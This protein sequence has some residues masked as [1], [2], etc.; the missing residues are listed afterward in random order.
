MPKRGWE[1]PERNATSEDVYVNRRK[2]LKTAGLSSLGAAAL[3]T[4]CGHEK[5]FEPFED[6]SSPVGG[7]SGTGGSNT[8]SNEPLYPA[9]VNDAFKELDRP[10]TDE[11]IAGS[12]NNF[13]EFSQGKTGIMKLAESF[14]ANPWTVTVDG[15][16]RN[17]KTYDL[18]DLARRMPLEERL[19]RL[20]CV[21]AW[22]MAIPWTGFPMKALIDE[23]EP[24]SNASYVKMTTF[25]DPQTAPGQWN[26]PQWPWPYVEGLRMEEA[27]NELSL[28]ATGIY[29][30]ALPNQHGAP[31]RLVVPWKYGFK[32]IKSI[33]RIEFTDTAPVTFWNTLVPAEY[34]FV[35]NV[36]PDVPHPRWSQ[37]NER[38]ISK[39]VSSPEMRPTLPYNGYEQY[40]G[41]LYI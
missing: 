15:L 21:E 23:V 29:G 40:V 30:H 16:V 35:A 20:R 13:Y 14:S 41:H 18:D 5:I 26:N 11:I 9:R 28:L 10:L 8:G 34:G 36:E 19:Y 7:G 4:G 37:A 17:P 27:M 2:F 24:L 12:Y 39:N 38:F 6:T 32:N 3:L 22:S 1:M 33:V 31:V 25:I